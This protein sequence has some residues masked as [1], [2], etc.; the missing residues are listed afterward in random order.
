MLLVRG[1]AWGRGLGG[2]G[3]GRERRYFF[4]PVYLLSLGEDGEGCVLEDQDG[5]ELG[6][7]IL[8]WGEQGYGFMGVVGGT[9]EGCSFSLLPHWPVGKRWGRGSSGFQG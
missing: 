2:A 8:L 1:Q 9:G 5:L 4:N 6:V 3:E 7:G